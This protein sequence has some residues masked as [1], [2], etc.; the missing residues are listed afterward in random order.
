MATGRPR[1]SDGRSTSHSN[2]FGRTTWI[3]T[4]STSRTRRRRSRRRSARSTSSCVPGRYARSAAP[5]SRLRSWRRP[6]ASRA[7]LGGVRF[8]VL[9]NHYSVIRRD[10]DEDVLP[11]C[12]ELGVS[13]IP[14]F[15]LASGLLT[16][17]VPAGRARAGR[18]TPRGTRDRGRALRPRRSVR[19]LC[20]GAWLLTARARDLRARFDAGRRLDHRRGDEARAGAS[21]RGGRGCVASRS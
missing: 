5:I 18:D 3:S 13:Y 12:R 7:T 14:Y 1:T 17:Q 15:P 2:G 20:G 10:D 8:T 16:G 19:V 4:T 9:Q 21:E 11:L 6:T